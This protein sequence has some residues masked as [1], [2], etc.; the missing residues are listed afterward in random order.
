VQLR[1]PSIDKNKDNFTAI[2]SR[3]HIL[4]TNG[5]VKARSIYRDQSGVERR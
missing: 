4:H 5:E 2:D 3:Q 1:R